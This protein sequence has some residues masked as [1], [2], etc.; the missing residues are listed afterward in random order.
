V[1]RF[2]VLAKGALAWYKSKPDYIE[3]EGQFLGK[4]PLKNISEFII[5]ADDNNM[6]IITDQS[7]YRHRYKVRSHMPGILQVWADSACLIAPFGSERYLRSL[8][9]VDLTTASISTVA[10][11]QDEYPHKLVQYATGT[12]ALM[13][14]NISPDVCPKGAPLGRNFHALEGAPKIYVSPRHPRTTTMFG[15]FSGQAL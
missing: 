8:P 4:I 2:F 14:K 9:T 15:S 12:Q 5:A 6:D 7:P 3:G 13:W 1:K 10:P 11:L